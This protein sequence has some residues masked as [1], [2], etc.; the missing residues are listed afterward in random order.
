MSCFS[1]YRT[2]CHTPKPNVP[3][4]NPPKNIFPDVPI[5]FD[6]APAEAADAMVMN[7]FN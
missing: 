4:H 3:A 6:A 5:F 2:V 7:E 1:K